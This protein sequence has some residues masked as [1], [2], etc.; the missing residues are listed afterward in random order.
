MRR[1]LLVA[2]ALAVCIPLWTGCTSSRSTKKPAFETTAELV[3]YLRS[4][5]V[6]LMSNGPITQPFL[7]EPGQS[8]DVMSGGTLHVF[9]YE[10][11]T[12]ASFDASRINMNQMGAEDKPK[13]FRRGKLI[14]IFFGDDPRTT[15][16]LTEGMGSSIL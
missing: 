9:E 10:S 2:T 1:F 4:K 7:L 8:Y 15:S 16:V 11:E 13:V 12:G 5:R 14:A 3:S 6:N